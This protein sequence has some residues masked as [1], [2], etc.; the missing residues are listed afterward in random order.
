MQQY[1]VLGKAYK[2][3]WMGN[4]EKFTLPKVQRVFHWTPNSTYSHKL[5][6]STQ[7]PL[8]YNSDVAMKSA[9]ISYL[10]VT[11]HWTSRSSLAD[12]DSQAASWCC[13]LKVQMGRSFPIP[14][15]EDSLSWAY[16]RL[17]HTMTA[18]SSWCEPLEEN[19]KAHP[20]PNPLV[21]KV[22]YSLAL[23]VTYLHSVHILFIRRQSPSQA[24]VEREENQEGE[25]FTSHLRSRLPHFGTP[26]SRSKDP[27]DKDLD[28]SKLVG[29]LFQE[30]WISVSSETKTFLLRKRI[31]T[32]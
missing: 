8:V 30:Y 2:G 6:M 14:T 5:L 29:S 12:E 15:S 4:H 10:V 25:L 16:N 7:Y 9:A 3:S 20:G 31:K 1:W 21:H 19:D 13:F 17:P 24:S 18:G 26:K 23:E 11:V 27:W 32:Q 22:F 28:A